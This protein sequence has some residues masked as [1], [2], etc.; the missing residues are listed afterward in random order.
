MNLEIPNAAIEILMVGNDS[1]LSYLIKRYAEQSGLTM[2]STIN[3]PSIADLQKIN[4]SFIIFSSL[5]VL[6]SSQA[7]IVNLDDMAIQILVCS[8]IGEEAAARES[9]ADDCLFHPLTY[10]DFRNALATNCRM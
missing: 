10:D 7:W 6:Q 3:L 2:D 1:M 8:G 5:D 9:G 4:P